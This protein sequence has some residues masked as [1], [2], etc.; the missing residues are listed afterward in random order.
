[1]CFQVM[2]ALH[3]NADFDS[4]GLG[5][6]EILHFEGAPRWQPLGHDH[7]LSSEA[8]SLPVSFFRFKAAVLFSEK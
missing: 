8:L 5:R 1:M 6:N 4:G 3:Q 7:S 2:W